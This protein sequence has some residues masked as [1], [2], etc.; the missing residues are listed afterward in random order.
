M[1]ET[2]PIPSQISFSGEVVRKST[3]LMSLVF[4][5]GYYFLQL[6][7]AG[8]LAV[9]IP[10]TVLMILIDIAR[11][12]KWSFWQAFARRIL[13]PIIRHHETAGDFTG[14]TYILLAV[15]LTVALYEKSIAVAA[16]AFIIV[17]DTLAALIGRRFGRHRFGNKSF[18]GSLACLVGTLAVACVTP[19]LAWPIAVFGAFVA[20]IVEALPLG[21]DDN[22]SVPILSGL[23]MTLFTRILINI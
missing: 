13:S 7:R 11:L 21:I 19:G 6:S 17:G 16:I 4:P 14:A 12:R 22:I 2:N 8:M 23:S 10:I 9:M 20:T 3:H 18:E 15:C 1:H 5:A